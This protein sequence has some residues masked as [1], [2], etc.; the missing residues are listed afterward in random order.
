MTKIEA[1]LS[2]LSEALHE[3]CSVV[4]YRRVLK[5]CKAL[6]LTDTERNRVTYL[7]SYT[8]EDGMLRYWLAEDLAKG[9]KP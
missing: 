1:V 7:L 2:L 6:E 5:A 3:K 8:A 9:K 4:R